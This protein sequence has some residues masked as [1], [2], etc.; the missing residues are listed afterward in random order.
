MIRDTTITD[1]ADRL[2]RTH[3]GSLTASLVSFFRL[4]SLVLAEDI[5]QNAFIAALNTWQRKGMPDDPV[6]WLYKVCRNKA[7]NELK[8]SNRNGRMLPGTGY[9]EGV[10]VIDQ[11]IDQ[12]FAPDSI[13]NSRLRLLFAACHPDFRPK[14]RIIL[15]LKTLG[16]L[17]THEIAAALNMKEDAVRK[18]LNRT[19]DHIIK[20]NIPL[21]VPYAFQSHE[22]L[23]NVHQVLYL[24]FNEGYNATSGPEVLRRELCLEAMRH[25]ASLLND[26]QMPHSATSALYALMLFNVA[27]FDS[28]TAEDGSLVELADQDRELWDREI[29]REGVSYFLKAK[30]A[31]PWSRYHY[32]AAIASLHATAISFDTTDWRGIVR[33]YNEYLEVAGDSPFVRLNK[34][35][36]L[37]YSGNTKVAIEELKAIAGIDSHPLSGFIR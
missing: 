32:E 14:A 21:H 30:A 37:H 4:S 2:Y 24:M 12:A 9:Y 19:R 31:K 26:R 13:A 3:Y 23:E 22:R 27:R 35:L 20:K 34:A 10:T 25:T 16:G 28:R 11:S 8:K 15:T 1:E 5:V 7:I 29:I 36:A 18:S 6:A 17:R 33:L